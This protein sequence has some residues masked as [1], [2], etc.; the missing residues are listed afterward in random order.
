MQNAKARRD[1]NEEVTGDRG[2]GMIPN[3]SGPAL[4]GWPDRKEPDHG[5]IN[6]THIFSLLSEI[7]YSG[8]IGCEYRPAART[9]DGLGWLNN[10]RSQ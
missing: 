8:W 6:Y 4:A 1:R 10:W 5:E 2:L 7:G 3:E 9:E